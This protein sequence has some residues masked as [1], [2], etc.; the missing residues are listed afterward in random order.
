MFGGRRRGL[1]AARPP[2]S[3][4]AHLF[5]AASHLHTWYQLISWLLSEDYWRRLCAALPLE[6]RTRRVCFLLF[7]FRVVCVCVCVCVCVFGRSVQHVL[8]LLLINVFLPASSVQTMASVLGAAGSCR[9][10]DQLT[11]RLTEQSGQ[12]D[13]EDVVPYLK[14]LR[15]DSCS[16][17]VRVLQP[18][19]SLESWNQRGRSFQSSWWHRPLS[20]SPFIDS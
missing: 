5:S 13:V 12:E 10:S 11:L 8:K 16:L 7:V 14:S 4:H 1:S 18:L 3:Q 17:F 6:S 2:S 15:F 19:M 20:W 9:P